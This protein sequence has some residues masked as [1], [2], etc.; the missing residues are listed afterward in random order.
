MKS[1]NSAIK[2]MENRMN[3]GFMKNRHEGKEETSEAK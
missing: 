2:M 3:S 1:N